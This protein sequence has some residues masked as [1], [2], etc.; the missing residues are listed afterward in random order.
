MLS[1]L[2]YLQYYSV[3]NRLVM[4]FKRLKQPKYLFGGVVGLLYFYFYFFRY[5]FGLRFGRRGFATGMSPENQLLYE[6]LGGLV[7]FVLVF[8][9]W[10]VPH[11]RAGLAFSGA[12]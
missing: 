7:L 8:L 10:G 1:A 4:R 2:V 9:A 11:P 5:V 6:C 12:E 3:R